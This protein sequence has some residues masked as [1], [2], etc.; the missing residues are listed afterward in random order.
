MKYYVHVRAG[1]GSKPG[2]VVG[3]YALRA[4]YLLLPNGDA[5]GV[6]ERP[7]HMCRQLLEAMPGVTVL[8]HPSNPKPLPPEHVA[9]I[10]HAGVVAGDTMWQ[11]GEKLATFHAD[12]PWFHPE[13]CSQPY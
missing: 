2:S 3:N 6:I 1:S 11:A 9:L 10:A 13:F 8:L 5:I 4:D 12:G 7:A